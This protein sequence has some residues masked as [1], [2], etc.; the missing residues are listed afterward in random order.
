MGDFDLG[1]LP[2]AT[3]KERMNVCHPGTGEPLL[4]DDGENV[5]IELYGKDSDQY[6]KAQRSI[7]DRRLKSRSGSMTAERLEAEANEVLAHCVADWNIVVGGEVPECTFKNARD[8][9]NR[10]KWLK[11]QVDEFIAE[12]ANFLGV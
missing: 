5:F 9:F 2:G 11:E 1:K 6:R 10:F 4:G 12:R 8:M 7:S 3:D